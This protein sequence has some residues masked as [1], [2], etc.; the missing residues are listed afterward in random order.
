M[1]RDSHKQVMELIESFS[2][3]ELF[4][5][6]VLPWMGTSVLVAYCV[7]ATVSHYEWAAKKIKAHIKA[8]GESVYHDCQVWQSGKVPEP[9]T[10]EQ[11]AR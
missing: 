3:E 7:S 2:N 1:L 6:G 4:E 9:Y 10:P 11:V 5:S 8:C